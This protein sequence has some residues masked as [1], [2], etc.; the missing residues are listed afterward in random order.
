MPNFISF[1]GNLNAQKVQDLYGILDV[2][3]FPSIVESFGFPLVEAM[4]NGL[5]IVAADTST[6]RELLGPD[7]LFFSHDDAEDLANRLEGI[8]SNPKASAQ[9]A[10]QMRKRSKIFSWAK[11]GLQTLELLHKAAETKNRNQNDN[12]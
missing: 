2:F 11:A 7:G 12:R 6:N 1:V 4:A 10:V 8:I 3:I 9:L 5:P